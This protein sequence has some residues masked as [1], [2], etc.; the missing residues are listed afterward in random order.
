[1]KNMHKLEK[2]KEGEFS[3]K[4]NVTTRWAREPKSKTAHSAPFLKNLVVW[5]AVLCAKST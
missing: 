5:A 3:Q 4:P 1:M 2:S